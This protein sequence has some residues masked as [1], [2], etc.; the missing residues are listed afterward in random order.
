MTRQN[1]VII[2]AGIVGLHLGQVLQQKGHDVF[3]L[4]KEPY[5]AEHTSG[6]NSGVIH[7][8]IFYKS[9]SLKESLCIAGNSLTYE[10]LNRLA[11][12]HRNCG[13]WIVP[14]PG[15]EN[16]LHDFFAR[17]SQLPIPKPLLKSAAEVALDEPM[18]KKTEAILIPSTGILD[19]ASYVKRL[20][21]YVENGGAQVI[22]NCAVEG[23][24]N[25]LIKTTRGE[26]P[27][28]LA[29][30][31]AGLFSDQIAAW[32]ELNDYE[33]RPCRGDYYLNVKSPISRPI[34]HIPS[35]Q[36]KGLGVHLTPTVDGQLLVGPNAF[37]IEKKTDYQHKSS[38]EQFK[39]SIEYYLPQ[40]Q[41]FSLSP[42]YSGNRPKLYYQGEA[43]T[44]FKIVRSKNFVHLL[45]IESPGMTAAPALAQHVYNLVFG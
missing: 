17:I 6:R 38:A 45:G 22:L 32:D 8:G 16:L 31:C 9:G 43:L 4:E 12:P 30:N 10:W 36:D 27:F 7:A 40:W 14:D 34:Y 23:I 44:E 11:V 20:S 25:G 24:A 18:L 15:Q 2:G 41:D 28:D 13:K 35:P 3:I 42:A 33:I 39:A 5:L 37:M 26:I 29:F 21:N 1:I 19:A